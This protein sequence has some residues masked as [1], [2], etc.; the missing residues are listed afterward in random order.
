MKTVF[1]SIMTGLIFLCAWV[2]F[3]TFT[4]QPFAVP[5]AAK[6][7]TYSAPAIAVYWYILGAAAIGI[8]A[9]VI[10]TIATS[11]KQ[12]SVHSRLQKRIKE[13][14]QEVTNLK[15]IPPPLPPTEDQPRHG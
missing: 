1:R 15:Q 3:A 14:E 8:I 7:L 11:L 4:Q 12:R 2:F 10:F 9:A 5:V 13:L 6:I